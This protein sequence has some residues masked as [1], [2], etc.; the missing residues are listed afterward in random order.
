LSFDRLSLP[1]LKHVPHG[2]GAKDLYGIAGRMWINAELHVFHSGNLK[3]FRGHG[4]PSKVYSD[5]GATQVATYRP[6]TT[7]LAPAGP[8]HNRP[9]RARSIPNRL[10]VAGAAKAADRPTTSASA[11]AVEVC[12]FLP[13]AGA[14][15][16]SRRSGIGSAGGQLRML[17]A[18]LVLIV[19]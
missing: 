13:F 12:G 17:S 11:S 9:H 7:P 18:S 4:P 16:E 1:R 2:T 15:P 14:K 8:T 5:G 6:A 3:K 19:Q 10:H